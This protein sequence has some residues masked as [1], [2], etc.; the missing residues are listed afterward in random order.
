MTPAEILAIAE[1]LAKARPYIVEGIDWAVNVFYQISDS[2]E[3]DLSDK[4]S[5]ELGALIESI[6][7][8]I[9]KPEED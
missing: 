5:Q 8:S 3:L 2:I 6:Q 7:E 4:N 9:P 1:I